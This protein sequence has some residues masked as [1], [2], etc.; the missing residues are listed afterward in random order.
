MPSSSRAYASAKGT[1]GAP[2]AGV[3]TLPLESGQPA[4][5]LQRRS[6]LG[7][8]LRRFA[9]NKLSL[10]GAVIVAGLALMAIF[11]DD[12]PIAWLL[13]RPPRPLI[14]HYPYDEIFVGPTGAFPSS[15]F[16]M[17]TDLN[18]RDLYSR[19]VYAA[20]I[21][22]SIGILSQVI[23]LAI[24]VPLGA[25][26]GWRGGKADFA[27]MRFVDIM[28]ALPTL[29]L[30]YLIM[31]RLGAGYWNVLIAIG[32]T[33]WIEICR[34]TRAQFLS[35][36][37]RE[38]VEAARMVGLRTPR[39]LWLHML[40]NALATIIVS[41]TLGIPRAIFAEASLSFLGVGINPPTPSWGQMLG[42]DGIA[43]MTF[44][45]HLAFFPA[46]MIALT[47]T[48]FTLMG[49]GLRDA[50]DPRMGSDR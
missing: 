34:L 29:L 20:R 18:G 49:D 41:L 28:S 35:L 37:E 26:A 1:A 15:D 7:D 16:W 8:A 23:A 38:F 39:I 9:R 27:V 22:L 45:W 3:A 25:L 48:G 33:S 5:R 21:S 2:A 46:L 6:L 32:V 30:A 40:P 17:G 44:F 31:A 19:I 10:A 24:G 43:N 36:R 14:A 13:G 47:M 4:V 50:L 11:A 12:W 42:R